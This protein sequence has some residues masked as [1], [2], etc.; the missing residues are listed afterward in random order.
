MTSSRPSKRLSHRG[1]AL[2][3]AATLMALVLV[4]ASLLVNY[5]L[6][7]RLTSRS[8]EAVVYAS[9]V[10]EAGIDKAVFCLNATSGTKCSGT[11]GSNFAGETDISL[12]AGK[13]TTVVSGSGPVRT[14]T[15]TGTTAAGKSQ[16][17]TAEITTVPPTDNSS[18]S[19]ALQSGDGGA[20]LENNSS[21]QGT[22]Y[23]GGD[24]DCTSDKA[25]VSGDIYSSKVGGKIDKCKTMYH[26]H[27]DQILN[28]YVTKNAFYR[29]DPADI[30]GTTVKGTKYPG[31]TRPVA[32]DLPSM[33]LEF[34]HESAE[35]GGVLYGNQTPADNSHLGP[36]KI[37]GNLILDQNVDL[38]I[39]GPVWVVGNITTYNNSSLTLNSN[40]GVYSTVILADDPADRA[41]KGKVTIVN[42]TSIFGSGNPKSH[43]LIATTNTSTDDS[44]P[45]MSIANNASGAIF[46]ALNGT[47]RLAN[48]GGAKSLAGKRLFL[49]QNAVV[50]YLESEISDQQFSNSPGGIWRIKAG[51][52]REF[53]Q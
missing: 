40:F 33:N 51:T 12:D 3:S 43:I 23:T 7:T 2:I 9:S 11:F 25:V 45:A 8:Y 17:I 1:F 24:V 4:F 34:W 50:T 21:I 36:V 18:F 39:D 41:T 31:S 16:V 27:A 32:R 19:Y 20:H 14:V 38:I 44:S 35:A 26:A 22:L 15:V 42:N 53:R 30:A 48:N 10:A 49:D 47:L 28:S 29:T 5:M 6:S 46:Y 13:F 52:W 37:V